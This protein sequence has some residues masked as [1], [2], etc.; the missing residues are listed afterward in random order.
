[1]AETKKT[2]V[3]EK[4]ATA[5]TNAIDPSLLLEDAGTAAENMTQDD[6]MIPRISILQ[7]M[8][9]QLIEG[10]PEYIENS[11][12]GQI[13]ENVDKSVIDG[14]K[15][16][17]VVPVSYR[18]AYVEW[19]PDRKGIVT[20]HGSDSKC[21]EGCENVKGIHI[22]PDGNEI[23][24]NGE[25]FV[26]VVNKDGFYPALISMN[27]SQLK[28]SK[29]WN[30][31]INRLSIPHPNGN[32]SINP[33]MFWTSYTLTTV[34]ES[35]DDGHW[36]GWDIKMMYDAQSG[37][38]LENLPNGADIYMAARDFRQRIAD[39]QVQAT[40]ETADEESDAEVM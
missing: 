19:L 6:M 35:N 39:N 38:I 37:G 15:G 23:I 1:M 3:A 2:E 7:S 30:S 11:K 29:R 5:V 27:K 26:F 12:A 25:Y 31:M 16:I 32:G 33:A 9:K 18:R 13:F 4:K 36:F 22:T 8:S 10:K 17:T 21:L 40:P 28:K 20:D 34:P 24:T 14:K